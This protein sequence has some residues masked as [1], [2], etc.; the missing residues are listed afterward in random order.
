MASIHLKTGWPLLLALMLASAL[1]ASQAATQ[2]EPGIN[3]P[4]A[5]L[6]GDIRLASGRRLSYLELGAAGKPVLLLLHGKGSSAAESLPLAQQLARDFR[7]LALDFRGCGFSDWAPDG[8]YTADSTVDDVEQ[9]VA[10]MQLGR[11]AVYG[12]SYG[13]VIGI[14][15]A[16]RN[17]AH[18]ALLMLGDGGPA[19]LPDGSSPVLNPGQLQLAGAPAPRPVPVVFGNWAEMLARQAGQAGGAVMAQ[20][21]ESRFVRTGDGSVR[22]RSDVLGLWQTARGEAFTQP[23]PLVRRLAMPTL[24]LRAEYGLVPEQVAI[25]MHSA[26]PRVEQV[27]IAGAG[28]RIYVDRPGAV[29]DALRSFTALHAGVLN[30]KK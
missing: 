14:A 6:R 21:L 15:Y 4:A 19:T 18:A 13:A 25:A 3:V 27:L 20:M 10:A 26:N 23:W 17:P 8:D 1:P 2:P 7:V 16:A 29:L 30:E 28:H 12:Q 22:Q 24:L 11:F 5:A 9:F